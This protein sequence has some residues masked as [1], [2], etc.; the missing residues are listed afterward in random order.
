MKK[1]LSAEKVCEP[2][3]EYNLDAL[4]PGGI[5]GKY[6]E[7]YRAGTNLVLLE[8]EIAKVFPTQEAVNDALRLVMKLVGIAHPIQ[9]RAISASVKT[10]DKLF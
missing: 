5:Q 1:K 10:V 6:V 4:L 9:Q 2:D 7:R 8:P 3:I